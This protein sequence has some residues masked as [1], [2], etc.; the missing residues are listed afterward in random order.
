MDTLGMGVKPDAKINQIFEGKNQIQRVGNCP[1][2]FRKNPILLG[3]GKL[4]GSR[5]QTNT[6]DQLK[7]SPVVYTEKRSWKEV[8]EWVCESWMPRKR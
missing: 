1:N 6:Q 5:S 2:S 8:P 4:P 7:R 3:H